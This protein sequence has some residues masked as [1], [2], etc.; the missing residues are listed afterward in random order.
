MVS[1]S[2]LPCRSRRRAGVWL[3]A[4]CLGLP[5]GA[6]PQDNAAG[7]PSRPIRLVANSL[8]GGMNDVVGRILSERFAAS[9]DMNGQHAIVDNRPGG[10]GIVPAQYTMQAVADGHTLLLADL[11]ITAI[12]PALHEKPPFDPARDFVPVSLVM[13]APLFLAVNASLGVSTLQELVAMAKARP[14]KL[15]Y[16]SS[17]PGSVHHLAT[18]ALKTSA[19]IDLVHVPY[20][21][22]GQSTPALL[23][24]DV[25]VLFTALG[26]I[27]P[28]VASGRVKL[29]GVASPQRTPQAPDVPA[30]PE[31]GIN[32][33]RLEPSVHALVPAGTSPAV[34]AR[35]S[36][37]I[38]KAVTHPDAVRRFKAAGFEPVGSTPEQSAAQIATDRAF[39][40]RAVKA[41][42]VKPSN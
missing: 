8:P 15:F 23:A 41:A 3:A 19:G 11:S 20:K 32:D 22:S 21:S 26:P 2:S 29:L 36:A 31:A 38:R 16:G 25:Q 39:Y 33:V 12:I 4:A 13:T 9:A 34:V 35:L 1:P 18:E 30:F 10:G 37:E 28:H 14:G 24:N 7:F 42:G 5:M 27:Q 6:Q 40:T 17:G